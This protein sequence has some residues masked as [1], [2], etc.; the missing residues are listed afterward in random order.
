VDPSVKYWQIDFHSSLSEM[1][2]RT[3][4]PHTFS[5]IYTKTR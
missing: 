3:D 4:T 5:S 1:K 2:M